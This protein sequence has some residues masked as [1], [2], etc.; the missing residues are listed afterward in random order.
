MRKIPLNILSCTERV[1]DAAAAGG[2]SCEGVLAN[3]AWSQTH[4]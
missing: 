4:H 3:E 2:N 1:L